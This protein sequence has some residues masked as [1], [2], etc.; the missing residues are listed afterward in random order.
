MVDVIDYGPI[1][2]CFK[3]DERHAVRWE[4][5]VG[6]LERERNEARAQRD[7]LREYIVADVVDL[8]LTGDDNSQWSECNECGATGAA[9]DE[10][11]HVSNCLLCEDSTALDGGAKGGET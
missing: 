5:W 8:C 3:C 2:L 11:E 4:C 6:K 10:P 1:A 9:G 7:R